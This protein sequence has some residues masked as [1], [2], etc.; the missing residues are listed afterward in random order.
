[1]G[2]MQELLRLRNAGQ[3]TDEQAQWFRPQRPAEEL[4]DTHNDPHELKNLA[5]DPAYSDKLAELREVCTD[6]LTTTGD[7][8]TIPEKDLIT[9]MWGEDWEQPQTNAPAV[10]GRDQEGR[11]MLQSSTPGST[12]GYRIMPQD[13]AMTSWRVYTAP[14]ERVDGDTIYARADRIGYAVSELSIGY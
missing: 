14:L 13:S 2:A 12:I 8:G 4:F 1:M 11:F 10:V 5:N 6:W 3:L 9:Q 7:L